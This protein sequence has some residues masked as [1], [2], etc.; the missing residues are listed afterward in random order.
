[1]ELFFCDGLACGDPGT[2]AGHLG[3]LGGR[4]AEVGTKFADFCLGQ[5]EL[6]ERGAD[7]KLTSR[8]GSG[9]MIADVAGILTVGQHLIP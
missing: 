3:F 2:Q 7:L 8:F 4:Q 9:A 6:F 5:T 1:M